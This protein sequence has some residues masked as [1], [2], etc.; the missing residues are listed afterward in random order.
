MVE[1]DARILGGEDFVADILR[2][3]DKKLKRQLRLGGRKDFIEQVIKK[4]CKEEGVKEEELRNGG[5]RRRVSQARAR[6]SYHLSHG[7]GIPMA[8]I[9]RHVGV[10]TSA[11]EKAIQN[12]ES[13]N[14]K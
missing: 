6:I 14:E 3:A 5:R 8:E 13:E 2:E 1:H 9:A 11:V 12:M 7:F 10:C 4:L